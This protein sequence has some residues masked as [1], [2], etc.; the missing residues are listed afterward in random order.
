[1]VEHPH[2]QLCSVWG[3]VGD[4]QSRS[5]IASVSLCSMNVKLMWI[6]YYLWQCRQSFI[7]N[8]RILW[9]F[10]SWGEKKQHEYTAKSFQEWRCLFR[11]GK[12]F[13]ETHY[14]REYRKCWTKE[15]ACN[16]H[17]SWRA[18]SGAALLSC[19]GCAELYARMGMPQ[20]GTPAHHS[21][22]LE[23]AVKVQSDNELAEM[24]VTKFR[25]CGELLAPWNSTSPT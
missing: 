11:C 22:V 12:R 14:F 3:P 15:R 10:W 13:A 8:T 6:L 25:C 18:E 5:V 7:N 2:V 1:M 17:T 21:T 20:Q 9:V 19:C 4:F 24:G 16:C 23:G